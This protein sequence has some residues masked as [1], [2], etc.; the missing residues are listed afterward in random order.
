MALSASI[1]LVSPS[2]RV[3]S[4]K[5][6]QGIVS[7]RDP[8]PKIGPQVYLGPIK[9]THQKNQNENMAHFGIDLIRPHEGPNRGGWAGGWSIRFH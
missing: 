1:D 9:S 4:V 8:D 2:A 6:Q 7:D 3:N 5:F